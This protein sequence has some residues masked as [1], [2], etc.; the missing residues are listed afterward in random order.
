MKIN[1]SVANQKYK[2]DHF[3]S[4]CFTISKLSIRI[5]HSTHSIIHS[6]VSLISG[7]KK[8]EWNNMFLAHKDHFIIG[9]E[10]HFPA[11]G[12]CCLPGHVIP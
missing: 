7:C 12:I 3:A 9:V 1:K 2:K 5:S 11:N 6:C 8:F 10:S 4:L